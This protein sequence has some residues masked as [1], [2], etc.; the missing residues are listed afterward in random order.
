MLLRISKNKCFLS[1][2]RRA[3]GRRAIRILQNRGFSAPLAC[4]FVVALRNQK[5]L[6]G[7]AQ[8]EKD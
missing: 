4:A 6:Q 3:A 7:G 8:T 5:N 1:F 2:L